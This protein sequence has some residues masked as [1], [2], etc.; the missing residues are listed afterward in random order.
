[1]NGGREVNKKGSMA[2]SAVTRL[3]SEHRSWGSSPVAANAQVR[4]KKELGMTG[5]EREFQSLAQI[6]KGLAFPLLS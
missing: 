2:F 4:T 3:R 6:D 5:C 1:M